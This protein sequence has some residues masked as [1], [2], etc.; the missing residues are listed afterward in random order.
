MLFSGDVAQASRG[1]QKTLSFM[2]A[3]T[4][5]TVAKVFEQLTAIANMTGGKVQT[6]KVDVIKGLLVACQ[7]SEAKYVIRALGS[8]DSL[9]CFVFAFI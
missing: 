3:P 8:E 6:K 9:R 4:R 1:S 5:L 7:N 2:K